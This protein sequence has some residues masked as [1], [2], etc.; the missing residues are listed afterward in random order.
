MYSYYRTRMPKKHSVSSK[1]RLPTV[2]TQ[3]VMWAVA[4]YATR[5]NNGYVKETVFAERDL[6]NLEQRNL[7]ATPEIVKHRNRDIIKKEVQDGLI[8]LT[9]ADYELGQQAREWHRNQLMVKRLKG[10]P[11]NE[12]ESTLMKVVQLEEFTSHHALETAICASTISSYLRGVEQEKFQDSVDHTPLAAVGTKVQVTGK[13]VKSV[14]SVNY[15][16]HFITVHTACN[17]SVFFSY[18][19]ALEPKTPVNLRGTVKA[20]RPDSTQLTRVKLEA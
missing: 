6:A 4:A 19:Q 2:L 13:V 8:N 9:P 20:H 14:Y 3:E 16:V 15:N 5:V 10:T 7:H 18:R 11:L 1:P 12:F 17:R